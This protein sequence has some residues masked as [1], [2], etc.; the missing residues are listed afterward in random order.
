MRVL[1]AVVT[2]FL[3]SSAARTI[4]LSQE[5][6]DLFNTV[7]QAERE[8]L[9][10]AVSQDIMYQTKGQWEEMYKLYDNKRNISLDQ[11]VHDMSTRIKL[12]RF[13]PYAVT[14]I[15]P[16]EYWRIDGCAVFAGNALGKGP[17]DAVIIARRISGD[18]RLDEV[19]VSP[20][21]GP[22]RCSS[23]KK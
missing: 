22:Q 13:T 8:S 6:P 17:T 10:E 11:F 21:K 7:P 4:T 14:Y 16:A 23:E 12:L 15:P 2:L 19:V 20:R 18:W 3:L 5:A 1:V 9:R